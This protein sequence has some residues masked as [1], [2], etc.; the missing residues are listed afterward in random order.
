M[1]AEMMTD[2]TLIRE[3]KTKGGKLRLYLRENG[4]S[5]SAYQKDGSK[6]WERISEKKGAGQ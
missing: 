3:R 2:G 4:H 1:G 5:V 6:K